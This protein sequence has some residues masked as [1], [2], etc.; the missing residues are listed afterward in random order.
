MA[1]S[2]G[3]EQPTL[4]GKAATGLLIVGWIAAAARNVAR[5][6]VPV[7]AAFL[8]TLVGFLLFAAAKV[9]V[10]AH[11][12]WLSVGTAAM[13]PAFANAYRLGYWLML[14]GVLVTFAG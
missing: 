7:P 10:I 1:R 2:I 6:T 8:L 12:R 11:G 14:V 9:S 4:L 13:T 5:G 3:D